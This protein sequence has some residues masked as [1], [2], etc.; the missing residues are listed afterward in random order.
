M[1]ATIIADVTEGPHTVKPPAYKIKQ[2]LYA[3][4]PVFPV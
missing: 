1:G 3:A 2:S 4:F